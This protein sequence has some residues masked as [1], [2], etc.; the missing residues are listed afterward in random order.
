MMQT[1]GDQAEHRLCDEVH[2]TGTRVV[3]SAVYDSVSRHHAQIGQGVDKS[4][5]TSLE[6][7]LTEESKNLYHAHKWE[8]SMGAFAQAHASANRMHQPV[9][10]APQQQTGLPRLHSACRSCWR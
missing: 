3:T 5:L 9:H 4:E 6:H 8:E 1:G 2:G 10:L 7:R